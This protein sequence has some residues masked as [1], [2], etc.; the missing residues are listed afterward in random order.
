MY[1]EEFEKVVSKILESL[2]DK[3]KKVLQKEKI[4]ILHFNWK[5]EQ[6]FKLQHLGKIVDLKQQL[7]ARQQRILTLLREFEKKTYFC[8][9]SLEDEFASISKKR[10]NNL[11]KQ[12]EEIE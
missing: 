3:F 6:Q 1:L 9:D 8:K 4:E 12:I 10:W 5:L 11:I 7:K 2:P